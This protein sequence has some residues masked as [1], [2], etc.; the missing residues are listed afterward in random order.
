MINASELEESK[1]SNDSLKVSNYRKLTFIL[2][3]WSLSSLD[4]YL[5]FQH[6]SYV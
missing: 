5:L 3:I 4:R 1:S 6:L 2:V